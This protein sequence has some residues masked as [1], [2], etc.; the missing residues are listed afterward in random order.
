M[1]LL[2]AFGLIVVSVAI[3]GGRFSRLVDLRVRHSWLVLAACAI[4][5]VLI[6]V[7][8]DVGPR[9]GNIVHLGTYAMAGAFLVANHRI[10]GV[11]LLMLGGSLNLVAIVA[12]GGVMPASAWATRV[13][14]TRAAVGEFA[15][16]RQ[17]THPKLLMFG[18]IM[19]I[20]ERWP[21]SNVFSIGDVVL[22]A[23]A[24]VL[25]HVACG[26]RLA[27]PAPGARVAHTAQ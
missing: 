12:N 1:I 13:A 9:L 14:G 27:A 17:V 22:I 19:A 6:S 7:M 18:D 2:V 11:K 3:A 10:P 24:A 8:P 4:Q 21:L 20:P 25:L 5:T 15:N 23:G 16:S 26:S